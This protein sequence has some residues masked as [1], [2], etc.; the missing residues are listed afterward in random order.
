MS[1]SD[2]EFRRFEP[3][4]FQFLEDLAGNNNRPW[5]QENKRRYERDVL[6]PCLAFVRAFRPRLRKISEFFVAGDRRTGGSLMRV[7]RDT[8]FAKDKTPYKTNVGIHFRHEFGRD[9]HAPGFYVHVAP[10]EC[11][12]AIGLWR[13][14]AAALGEIR[15]A[16]IES[17]DRWR[18][19]RDDKR[20]RERFRL[21]G[22]SLKSAPRGFPADHPLLEDL[23]R[24]DFVGW[25]DLSRREVLGEGFLDLVATAFAAGRP[26]MRFLCHAIKV[27]F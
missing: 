21:E 3:S 5:F 12:L 22:E 14:D 2:A 15:E 20:F 4:I 19:A 16:I 25:C 13:P 18:R 27:P 9:V 23:K 24:T 26:L 6:E 11:F 10:E 8:R 17:P 7:Y 1:V